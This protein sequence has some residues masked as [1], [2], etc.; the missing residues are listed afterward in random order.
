M[1]H[2]FHPQGLGFARQVLPDPA[3]AQ[4]P[5]R[6]ALRVVAQRREVRAPAPLVL[7]EREQRRVEAAQGREEEI[8]RRVGR[9]V[10]DCGRRVGDVNPGGG[11]C[12]GV[13]LVVAR[14]W[15]LQWLRKG[16]KKR[17]K[18]LTKG[19][20]GLADRDLSA[21]GSSF[22]ASLTGFAS[23]EVYIEKNSENTD[24]D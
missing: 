21:S 8:Q 11:A 2:D 14:A 16:E 7:A 23:E 18:K 15:T 17:E 4:D 6:L 3:H 22:H 1:I 9:R 5:Q 12:G 13:D 10:V 24:A 19:L 20:L